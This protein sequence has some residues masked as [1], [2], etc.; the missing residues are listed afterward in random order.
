M[1]IPDAP[2]LEQ[3]SMSTEFMTYS[4][5]FTRMSYTIRQRAYFDSNTAEEKTPSLAMAESLIHECNS[6][7]AKLPVSLSL[8]Y[9]PTIP[10]DQKVRILLLHVYIFYTRCIISRDFLIQKVER[11]IASLEEKALPHS[12]DLSRMLVLSEDCVESAHQSIR[13][14]MEGAPLGMIGYSWL[15]LFFVFHSILIVCADFLARPKNQKDTVKDIERKEMVR[16]MLNHIREMKLAATYTIL[17]KIAIQ[18]ANITGVTEEQDLPR[19]SSPPGVETDLEHEAVLGCDE[20]SQTLGKISDIR[21]DW[22]TNA[23]SSVDLDF[24]DTSEVPDTLS[25]HADPSTYPELYGTQPNTSE[26]DDWTAQTLRGMH[27]L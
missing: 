25:L 21:D 23:T 9:L 8:N 1:K 15:D 6:F 10:P 4:L 5:E 14:I 27:T 16:V 20:T 3:K 19:T 26:V 24:L 13:C 17:S 11:D 7:S 22:F 12:E 2:M 18:F